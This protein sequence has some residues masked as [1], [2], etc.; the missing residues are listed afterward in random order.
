MKKELN[1]PTKYL[2]G[3]YIYFSHYLLNELHF[4]PQLVISTTSH[5]IIS[6]INKNVAQHIIPPK[7]IY[8]YILIFYIQNKKISFTRCSTYRTNILCL[9]PFL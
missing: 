1:G 2:P 5:P 3:A 6:I 7:I 9:S 4:N 8:Y